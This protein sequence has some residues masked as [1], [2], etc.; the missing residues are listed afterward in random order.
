MAMIKFLRI[1]AAALLMAAGISTLAASETTSNAP[2]GDP[3]FLPSLERP[4]G[5]R[6]DGSGRYP[7]A[8]PPTQWERKKSGNTYAM[9][10]IV[11]A[12]PMPNI[13]VSCPIIVGPRMFITT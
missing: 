10:G 4:V 11:Y 7:G 13:G 5:W 8:N 12:T 1:T 6:G 9:K 2:L 3:K